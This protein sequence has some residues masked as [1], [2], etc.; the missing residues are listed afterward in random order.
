[1]AR[2][3]PSRQ[4]STFRLEIVESVTTRATDS[5]DSGDGVYDGSPLI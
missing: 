3:G 1:M 5:V 2:Q 4:D